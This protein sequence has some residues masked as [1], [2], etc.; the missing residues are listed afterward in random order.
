L[1]TQLNGFKCGLKSSTN[2][3]TS[4]LLSLFHFL[5]MRNLSM[6]TSTHSQGDQSVDAKWTYR[7]GYMVS[8]GGDDSDDD[9]EWDSP[10]VASEQEDK[11]EEEAS[12]RKEAQ[13]AS[14]Q[15]ARKE[16]LDASEHKARKEAR[17]ASK[18]QAK[19]EA[20]RASE[21]QD[22]KEEKGDAYRQLSA[23]NCLKEFNDIQYGYGFDIS[24]DSPP[25]VRNNLQRKSGEKLFV[26]TQR[27]SSIG[28]PMSSG[29][30]F[31]RTQRRSSINSSMMN[32]DI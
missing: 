27:R 24:P 1:N 12:A 15:Q 9:D 29:E 3:N 22:K 13:V 7:A 11:E 30:K 20:R 26:R 32:F 14:E 5:T 23:Q 6:E 4:R 8:A 10:V 2:F 19:R 16:E 21:Q 25:P 28:A 17:R 31:K 18:R